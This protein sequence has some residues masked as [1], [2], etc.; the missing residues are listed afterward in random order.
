MY[1]VLRAVMRLLQH[2]ATEVVLTLRDFREELDAFV[3]PFAR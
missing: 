1:A 3:R 2:E